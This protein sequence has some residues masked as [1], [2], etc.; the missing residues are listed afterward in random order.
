MVPLSSCWA[1][2]ST[3]SWPSP[4]KPSPSSWNRRLGPRF[5]LKKENSVIK[6]DLLQVAV[7]V[8]FGPGKP[9]VKHS[10][11]VQVLCEKNFDNSEFH[12]FSLKAI[13]LWISEQRQKSPHRHFMI[14]DTFT[15]I[16]AAVSHLGWSDLSEIIVYY[17]SIWYQPIFHCCNLYDMFSVHT[18]RAP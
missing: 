10:L 11:S 13:Y 16:P 12:N 5:H 14:E 18:L 17:L 3:S 15:R 2:W 8:E 1:A 7:P 4:S 9:S 6:V